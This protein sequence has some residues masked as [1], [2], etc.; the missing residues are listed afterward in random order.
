MSHPSIERL[1]AQIRKLEEDMEHAFDLARQEY[2]YEWIQRHIVFGSDLAKI[3]LEQKTA[4]LKYIRHARIRT[5]LTVPFIYALIVPLCLLDLLV[6]LYQWVAFPV[7]GIKKVTRK[8]YVV[9][10]R[11]HLKYLNGLEKFNCIYCSYANGLLAYT[12]EV[13]AR[14]EDYWC[15]IKHA[16]R[17][18]GAHRLYPDFVDY[19]DAAGYQKKISDSR[20]NDPTQGD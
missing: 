9:F 13:A 1:R 6:G 3:H 19:G 20:S 10:D 5:M 15:P 11:G 2:N 16:R 14:T 7:Y 4:L 8:N 12:V 18:S 17:V